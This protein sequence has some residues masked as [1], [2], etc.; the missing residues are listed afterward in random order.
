[1]AVEE[2]VNGSL[3]TASRGTFGGCVQDLLAMNAE[4]LAVGVQVGGHGRTVPCSR[5]AAPHQTGLYRGEF[6]CGVWQALET[7]MESIKLT[8]LTWCV[9]KGYFIT[10]SGR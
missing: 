2:S 1:M 6:N 9:A 7:Q 8:I 10:G 4:G 5:V 3:Y